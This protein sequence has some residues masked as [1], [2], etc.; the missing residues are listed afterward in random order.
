MTSHEWIDSAAGYV[1]GE[2]DEK[3][4]AAFELHMKGC[5][6]CAREVRELSELSGLLAFAAPA[7]APAPEL[8]TRI[9]N[10]AAEVQPIGVAQARSG[11][12]RDTR[13][14]NTKRSR[15]VVVER[16]PWA[17]AAAALIF[18]IPT[19]MQLRSVQLERATLQSDLAQV[20]EQLAERESVL[21]ALATPDLRVARLVDSRSAPSVRLFWNASSGTVV[22]AGQSLA[23]TQPGRTYQLWAI[24]QGADPV[25]VG[26]FDVDASGAVTVVMQMPVGIEPEISA[27][28]EEPAGGSPGPTSTP[29]V[30]GEWRAGQ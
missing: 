17:I 15:S 10:D 13:V 8:R 27:V 3:N 28:T 4:R 18:A 24:V 9:M 22:V 29:F 23:A 25:S 26:T 21:R 30:V 11:A 7:V 5:A 2:L 12:Q 6:E 19:A 20:R 14:D 16:L 1:L